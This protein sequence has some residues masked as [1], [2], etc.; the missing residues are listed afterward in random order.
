MRQ[1]T[2]EEAAITA[3]VRERWKWEH[4]GTLVAF[5]ALFVLFAMALSLYPPKRPQ[6]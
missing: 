4:A 3:K 5:S 1:E 2:A 6:G